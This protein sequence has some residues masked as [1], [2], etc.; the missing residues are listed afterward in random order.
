MNDPRLPVEEVKED[1]PVEVKLERLHAR[2]ALYTARKQA[3]QSSSSHQSVLPIIALE[4]DPEAGAT[5]PASGEP[6][7]GAKALRGPVGLEGND[8]PQEWKLMRHIPAHWPEDLPRE[9]IMTTM[10]RFLRVIG[11]P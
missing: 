7:D 2:A 11:G 4:G 10:E 6:E 5:A 9:R 8:L 3:E 1:L